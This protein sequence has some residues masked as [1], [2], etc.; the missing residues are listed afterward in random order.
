MNINDIQKLDWDKMEGL[1]PAIIQDVNTLQVLML[2]YVNKESLEK[3]IESG[4]VTFYSRSRNKLWQK[5]ETS[6]NFLNVEE[7]RFDCDNDC[8]LITANPDGPTCHTGTTSCFGESLSAKAGWLKTLED[9]IEDR[10]NNPDEK[11]YTASLFK[12]GINRIAQKV[13]EEAVETSIAAV[14]NEDNFKEEAADLIFH[15]LVLL[16]AKGMKLG[17]IIDV[18]KARRIGK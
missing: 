16:K 13:G 9:V 3:T 10:F 4:K 18:L 6:G 1:I 14:T 11:S 15:L 17:D 12:K 5:G 2:G 7:I 8:L